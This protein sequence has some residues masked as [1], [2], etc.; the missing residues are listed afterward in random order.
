MKRRYADEKIWWIPL[1]IGVTFLI[2]LGLDSYFTYVFNLAGIAIIVAVGLDLLSG[3]TGLISLGHAAFM[4]VGAYTSAVLVAQFDWP[5]LLSVLA[6]GVIAMLAGVILGFPALRLSG[7][8]L[9]IVTMGFGVIVHRIII[10]LHVWTGGSDGMPV[11]AAQIFGVEITSDR[12][13]YYLIYMFAIFMT[14]VA[15]RLTATKMGRALVA[16]R[17][18][19]EAAQSSGI[20]LGRY[21]IFIFAV[22]AFYAGV[23]GA[24]YAHT[25]RFITTDYFN[26]LLSIQ[27][28]VM[29][30][31]GGIGSIYGAVLG[32]LFITFLP[33]FIR[34]VKDFLPP[35]VAQFNDL[36]AISFG[37]VMLF[38]ILFEPLGI[39]RRWLKIRIYWKLFPFNPKQR[40]ETNH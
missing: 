26:I 12:S 23:G 7:L 1:V 24:L 3:Y 39:Y 21:K 37:L 20:H 17:D 30:I 19:E 31:V 6:A 5:F 8:Y 36:Q 11:P 9:A 35:D 25:I 33:E 13:Q 28:L 22:S 40:G 32:A 4:A 27:F 38:F 16:I 15:K 14:V 2:P 10:E 18:S 29:I 34:V